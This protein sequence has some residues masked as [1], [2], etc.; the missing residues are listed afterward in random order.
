MQDAGGLA[1]GLHALHMLASE[2]YRVT[3]GRGEFGIA[4]TN[5]Y[6]VDFPA[7]YRVVRVHEVGH[8]EPYTLHR[9][10]PTLRTAWNA[11][12]IYPY[13]AMERLLAATTLGLADDEPLRFGD[14]SVAPGRI[15]IALDVRFRDRNPDMP[16]GPEVSYARV[17][18]VGR[19]GDAVRSETYLAPDR[20]SE[21][22]GGGAAV[23][24]GLVAGGHTKV[25]GGVFAPESAFVPTDYFSAM[26]RAGLHIEKIAQPRDA[27]A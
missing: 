19:A 13:W 5:A 8:P 18:V 10:F 25:R 24:T 1:V 6:D 22:A 3:D 17:D 15:A 2:V 7:P 11:G 20:M 27:L 14:E 4:D 9:A 16:L 21:G 26:E 12:A 23:A